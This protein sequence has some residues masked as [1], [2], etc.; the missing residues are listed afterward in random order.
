MTPSCL[1]AGGHRPLGPRPRRPAV[2]F[3]S[4]VL[5]AVGSVRLAPAR[6]RSFEG[7]RVG[8]CFRREPEA[9]GGGLLGIAFGRGRRGLPLLALPGRPLGATT[10][11]AFDSKDE[12]GDAPSESEAGADGALAVTP[13]PRAIQHLWCC[14][15]EARTGRIGPGRALPGRRCL[16][17]GLCVEGLGGDVGFVG[18]DDCAGLRIGAQSAEVVGIAQWLEDAAVVEQVREIDLRARAVLEADPNPV[19]VSGFG[20]GEEGGAAHHR[21]GKALSQWVDPL[22]RLV[23]TGAVPV[24]AQ[25]SLMCPCPLDD[26]PSG[27]SWQPPGDDGQVFD[28][29][30]GLVIAIACVEVRPTQVVGLIVVH[31]DHD[32]VEG[33]DPRHPLIVAGPSDVRDA[34]S[35]RSGG[36][37]LP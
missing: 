25:F 21:D 5:T 12:P 3:R 2:P 29:A 7:T 18:P 35:S 8:G 26:E 23:P 11:P 9:S 32:S 28:V 15:P 10:A 1:R 16:S 20:F 14:A 22:E 36:L 4:S 27:A 6:S 19:A 13:G 30:R 17:S 24:L 31:P 33:A 37:P 34:L